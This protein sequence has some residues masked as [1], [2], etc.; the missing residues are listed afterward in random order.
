MILHALSLE[1][2]AVE[3]MPY[4]PSSHKI[5]ANWGPEM[6]SEIELCQKH[7]LGLSKG[8]EINL[9]SDKPPTFLDLFVISVLP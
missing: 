9:C 2:T 5:R 6:A 3:A 1:A 8:L 7:P 4:R